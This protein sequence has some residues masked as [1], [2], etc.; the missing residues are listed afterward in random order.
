[1][2]TDLGFLLGTEFIELLY[3]FITFHSRAIKNS[4]ILQFTVALNE[5]SLSNVLHRLPK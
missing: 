1:V 5:Y 3:F 2:Y 4:Q